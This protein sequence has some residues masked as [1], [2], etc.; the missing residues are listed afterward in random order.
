MLTQISPRMRR[1]LAREAR[2]NR[3]RAALFAFGLVFGIASAPFMVEFNPSGVP[4]LAVYEGALVALLLYALG[5]VVAYEDAW[6]EFYDTYINFYHNY[7]WPAYTAYEATIGPGLTNFMVVELGA[8]VCCA[9]LFF[10]TGGVM[11]IGCAML[12]S[13]AAFVAWFFSS[14]I[15][16]HWY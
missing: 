7:T 6:H 5:Q 11:D 3:R 16:L 15:K 2:V 13:L 14:C 4:W 9:L 1:I 8:A 12:C 10:V